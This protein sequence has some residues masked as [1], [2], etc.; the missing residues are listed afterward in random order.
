M[1]TLLDQLLAPAGPTRLLIEAELKPLMGRRFQ[2]TG[3]PDLGAAVYDTQDGEFLVVE[4]SQSMANRL[5]AVCWDEVEKRPVPSLAGISYIRVE[6]EAGDYVTSS[7]TESHRINSPYI[8][9]SKDKSF[10]EA[11]QRDTADLAN[12][13]LDKALFAQILLKYDLGTLLHGVFLAK[14]E[15][16]GGRL[17]LERAVSAFIEAEGVRVA[18]LGGVKKD[19]VNPKGDTKKG[20]GHVPFH[21]DEYTADRIV[22]YFKVDLSQIRSYGLPTAASRL[23]VGLALYKIQKLL[24]EDMRLRTACDLEVSD[25]QVKRPSRLQLPTASEL[26]QALPGLI[27]ACPGLPS[28]GAT[29]VTWKA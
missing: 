23:L 9:E 25:V 11:L 21:R 29:T 2:P 18:A 17:R 27:A 4:S 26:E 20:F 19:E 15:L 7:L 1:N 24:S 14:K 5:E 8:L 13:P 22:A 16:A 12:G 3:F 10:F 28:D 6:D